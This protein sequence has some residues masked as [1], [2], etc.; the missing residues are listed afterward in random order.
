MVETKGRE[1][2]KLQGELAKATFGGKGEKT[3]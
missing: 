2:G 1:I 3:G